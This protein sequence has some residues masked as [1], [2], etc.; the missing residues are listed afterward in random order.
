LAPDSLSREESSQADRF[1]RP[2][3]LAYSDR[4]N[5]AVSRLDHVPD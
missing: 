5:V 1:A 2:V 3:L 4:Q